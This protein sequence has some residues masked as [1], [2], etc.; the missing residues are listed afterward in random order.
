MEGKEEKTNASESKPIEHIAIP[1]TSFHAKTSTLDLHNLSANKYEE[2]DPR[3]DQAVDQSGEQLRLKAAKG[4]VG[5][6]QPLQADG[7]ANVG[8]PDNVLDLEIDVRLRLES[9]PLDDVGELARRQ[10]R[11]VRR[12]RPRHAHLARRE[13][14]GRGARLP[15]AHDDGREAPGVELGV[16]T[17]ERDLLQVEAD[18]EVAR[19][20][21]VLDADEAGTAEA[22][23]R[24]QDG[25][26]QA[27]GVRWLLLLRRA[28]PTAGCWHGCRKG[29]S[30]SG[31]RW[32]LCL[33]VLLVGRRRCCGRTSSIRRHGFVSKRAKKA[34]FPST[35]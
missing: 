14:E 11:I 5:V 7:E 20:G 30:T 17:L 1:S 33:L 23:G 19:A 3:T 27:G 26:G 12:L 28:A 34:G 21:H 2:D 32:C 9:H 15:E 13:D 22:V 8:R 25:P 35:Y 10:G 18:A 4:A 31:G 29:S 24:L 16:P 6:D